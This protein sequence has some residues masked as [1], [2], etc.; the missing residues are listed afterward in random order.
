LAH[1]RKIRFIEPQSRPGRPFNAWIR[2][3]PL[4]GPLTLGTILHERGYDVSIYNEN[5]S[6]SLLDNP[7]AYADVAS[8]DVIGV[9][10]MTPTANRGY[11]LA[12]RLR[13]DAPNATIVFGGVHATFMSEEALGHGDIVIRGEAENII[14]QVASGA[15]KHG[16][17]SPEPPQ[18]LDALPT[19]KH[20]LIRDFDRLMA[21]ALK[22]EYY[23][24][25]VMTSRGCPHGCTYCSVT[26]MFGRKVRRQ[27]V[28]KAYADICQ[29]ADR[30]F[31]RL[32]FYD[33]NFT[34]DREW[35]RALLDRMKPMNLRFNAQ[36]RVDFHW[37]DAA[38]RERDDA[39]LRSMRKSGG[40]VLY[41]G[42]ETIDNDTAK[43][44]HKG[45]HG[46]Q[47]LE[48]RL[49]E[50]SQILHDT[51]LWLHGMFVLGPQHTPRTA[52]QIVNFAK[53]S[54]IE[55][56]QMSV[57]TPF[58]GTPLMEEM[59]PHLTFNK[60][61]GDWEYYDGTHCVYQHGHM[62]L[63][64]LQETLIS[65]HQKFYGWL[66]WSRRRLQGFMKQRAPLSDKLA[67][68]LANARIARTVLRDWRTE[69]A[70]FLETAVARRLLHAE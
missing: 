64:E 60:F 44:W 33:D 59:R 55:S 4:L 54:G 66:G 8:A 48:S 70:A 68:L 56:I 28:E 52:D 39:L 26:Q 41:I 46:E 24:L 53:S 6:G 65:A 31:K 25:P 32:F 57:L 58:P 10:I 16:I 67:L 3:W 36:T 22:Q 37:K 5:V 21:A 30:G 63:R 38:R 50:D 40:D 35:T 12:D 29:Y 61:P 19:L 11:T 43:Q 18:D 69:T 23:Q 14:E 27:S 47:D 42:Y 17:F 62:G 49:R 34:A 7:A 15:I 45:Y 9:S 2:R 51:G 1:A 13:K 20:D